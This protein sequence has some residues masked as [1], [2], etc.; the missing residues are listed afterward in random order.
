MLDVIVIIIVV[1]FM[2]VGYLRGIL[3]EVLTVAALGVAYV[4]SA[5]LQGPMG[6][7]LL[8]FSGMAPAFAYTVG[9]VMGGVLIYISLSLAVRL[10]DKRI[11]RTTAGHLV[12]W[13][14]NLGALGGL[15]FGAFMGFCALSFADVMYKM[16]PQ[17]DTWWARTAGE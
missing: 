11:G 16:D 2:I 7:L 13:N 8:K 14:R 15:L 9:R 17:A 10:A 6:E 3:H 4:A 5:R 12:A 1:T